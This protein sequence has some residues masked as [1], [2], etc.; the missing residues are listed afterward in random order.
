[1]QI[2]KAWVVKSALISENVTHM[3]LNLTDRCARA[4]EPKQRDLISFC[5]CLYIVPFPSSSL[6]VLFLV[7]VLHR[8]NRRLGRPGKVCMF[9][10]GKMGYV[11]EPG[12]VQ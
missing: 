10:G 1:M 12:N 2:V 7:R 6:S 9:S 3:E 11:I 5:W 8:I 4:G